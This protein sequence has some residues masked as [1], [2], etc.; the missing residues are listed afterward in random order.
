MMFGA[1]GPMRGVGLLVG[2]DEDEK[3]AG[4]RLP[5]GTVRRVLR[6]GKPYKVMLAAFSVLIVADSL[7]SAANPWLYK[8]IL[9]EGILRHDASLV[10]WLALSVGGLAV[11]DAAFGILERWISAKVGQSLVFDLRSKVFAHVQQM[12]IAFF[13]RTHTGALMSRLNNDVMGAQQ[14]FTDTFNSVVSNIVTLIVTVVAMT[15]LSWQLTL[16]SLV[17]LPAFLLPARWVGRRLAAMIR[18]SF[19]LIADMNTMMNEHFDVAGALLVKIFGQPD[20][21]QADFESKAVRVRDIGVK[22]GIYASVFGTSL[23]LTAS[24]GTAFLYGWGGDRAAHGDLSVGTLVAISLY[25]TRLYA[26]LTNLS[27]VQVDVKQVLVSFDRIFEVLGLHAM[28]SEGPDACRLPL[29]P[30]QVSFEHVSFHYPRADE[31]TLPSLS[32]GTPFERHSTQDVLEDVSFV[33]EPGQLVALVGPSGAGKTTIGQL[34]ARL[35]D[36]TSGTVRINGVDLRGATLRSVSETVGVVT[37][38]PHLFHDT[39]RANLLFARPTATDQELLRALADAQVLDMVNALP[40]GLDTVVGDR[41]QRLSGG[42]KQRIAVARLLLKSPQVVVLD[43][44]TAHLDSGS[45]VLLQQALKHAL[46]GRTSLVIAHRLSTVQQADQIL[47]VNHGRIIERGRHADLLA[48]D[49]LYAHL[50]RTQFQ[51]QAGVI[52]AVPGNP[53]SNIRAQPPAFDQPIRQ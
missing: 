9:D 36:P 17:L 4:Q 23:M 20:S 18:E 13:I 39:L 50:Y 14:A 45:E 49:N 51:R 2:P 34:V 6:F 28:I 3:L 26:P 29:G 19:S 32:S 46:A 8:D 15:V 38:D 12:P 47:V 41:G 31:V 33:A 43:E 22:T 30:A 21:V 1:G 35:Y 7:V 25:L 5:A 37:Q 11:T 52:A 40:A 42:E 44:A 48:G 27:S 53:D 16:L 24:L 10:V